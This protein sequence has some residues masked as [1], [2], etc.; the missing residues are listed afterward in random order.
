MLGASTTCTEMCGNGA[1]MNGAIVTKE[2]PPMAEPGGMLR[3]GKRVK[4]QQRSSC[5]AAAP[6]TTSPGAAAR[7]TASAASPTV[8][9]TASV[10]VWS[11]S[12]RALPLIH[13]SLNTRLFLNPGC[14]FAAVRLRLG[15][16]R[17]RA[18]PEW[19][20]RRLDFLTLHAMPA[21]PSSCSPWAIRVRKARN[22]ARLV[23]EGSS[24]TRA[25]SSAA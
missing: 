7:L 13:Q 6:G 4:N 11:A 23:G 15:G 5:C 17:L 19:R 16:Y 21:S 10:S 25:E 12:P 18:V 20:C 22:R 9:S 14:W 24:C 8:P 2:H 3:K 1:W